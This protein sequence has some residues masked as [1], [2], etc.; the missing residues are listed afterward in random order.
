M[1]K[2]VLQ[3]VPP[4]LHVSLGLWSKFFLLLENE[5]QKLGQIIGDDIAR[6]VCVC[7]IEKALVIS[8]Q[9][10]TQRNFLNAISSLVIIIYLFY[11]L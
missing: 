3:V 10:Y 11:F 2:F 9:F 7:I 5:L 6:K 1:Y 4:G 8:Q